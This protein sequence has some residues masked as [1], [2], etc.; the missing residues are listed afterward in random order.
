VVV[1]DY[2][3]YLGAGH[4]IGIGRVYML[5]CDLNFANGSSSFVKVVGLLL[6]FKIISLCSADWLLSSTHW[7]EVER[8][9]ELWLIHWSLQVLCFLL[10]LSIFI[11]SSLNKIYPVTSFELPAIAGPDWSQ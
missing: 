3:D 11:D 10:S 1:Q 2:T 8:G 7:K 5:C 9:S 6:N 4:V